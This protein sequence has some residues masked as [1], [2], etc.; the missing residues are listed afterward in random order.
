MTSLYVRLK[1]IIKE[2]L[3]LH[4][5]GL[6]I[7]RLVIF[8]MWRIRANLI[9]RTR[10]F[11]IND[12]YWVNPDIIE[13]ACVG[14]NYRKQD[15][16]KYL[17][18]GKILSGNW[19]LGK[20]KFTET[21]VYQSF[22]KHFLEGEK[23]EDTLLYKI[24]I[25]EI[26]KKGTP[27]GCEGKADLDIRLK[28]IDRLYK[29]IQEKGYKSQKEILSSEKFV[30]P[31]FQIGDEIVV[32]IGRNGEI[33]FEDG[34][35]RL[36]IAKILKL[37]LIPIKITVRHD[38][39]YSFRKEVLKYAEEN[40]K[41]VY[42][43]LPHIDLSDIPCAH[44]ERRYEMIKSYLPKTKEKM[45]DI[46][47]HWGYFCHK[48]EDH[49]FS[50]FAVEDDFTNLY[51]MEKLKKATNK[52]FNI[53]KKSIF[54]YNIK[55]KKSNVVLALNIF[56]HFLKNEK[57]YLKLIEFL[58]NIRTEI[59]FFESHLPNDPQMK[60]SYINYNPKEFVEFILSN[61]RLNRS[62]YLGKAEYNRPV[63]YLSI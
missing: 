42:N 30:S 3:A 28:G 31:L 54:N 52:R 14:L 10:N 12:I 38:N 62:L 49:G 25:E 22:I 63:F 46:G 59:M 50:C 40:D 11:D 39:W 15:F 36:A 53:I 33:L 26:E 27:Y 4:P 17:D 23:W 44:D 19:D 9:S 21:P 18:R 58:K 13:N 43:P 7:A 51:F 61:S 34:Q 24:L 32:R 2:I 48:F 1:I 37:A 16:N 55:N 56:H 6:E 60:D 8:K 47:A 41:K 29:D 5:S 35:H 45:L 20:I 57:S